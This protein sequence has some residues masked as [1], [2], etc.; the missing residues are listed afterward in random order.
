[1]S[2]DTLIN[3]VEKQLLKQGCPSRDDTNLDCMYRG[4]NQT[5]CG[6]GFLIPDNL[7]KESFEGK[8]FHNLPLYIRDHISN[9]YE[10]SDVR[11]LY[12]VL[13]TIQEIHDGSPQT[14]WS[15][16]ITERFKNLRNSLL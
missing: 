16:Y 7:Y 9:T 4:N 1:M 3:Y 8:I 11:E 2:I 12:G 15:E 13:N 6:V 5:K 10:I 14:N